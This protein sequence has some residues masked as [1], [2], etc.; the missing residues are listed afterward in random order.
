[1]CLLSFE[2]RCFHSENASNF[3]RPH[4]AREIRKRSN[5]RPFW[6]LCLR[7]TRAGESRDYRDVI[8]FLKGSLSKCFSS[9]LKH[10]AGVFSGFK[11]VFEKLRAVFVI[12]V[13]DRPNPINK[14]AFS[15]FSKVLWTGP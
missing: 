2:K 5:Q 11:N 1:M 6:D 14:A 4:Y 13:D 9:T 3:F 15:N 10:K 12:S 8:V 7:K